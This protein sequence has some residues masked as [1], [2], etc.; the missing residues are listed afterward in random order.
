[1]A[2]PTRVIPPIPICAALPGPDGEPVVLD[3]ATSKVAL[4]KVRV[5]MN[6]GVQGGGRHAHR[7][8]RP[9]DQRS[10]GHVH[11]PA[12]RHPRLRRA[13]GLR[14][15]RHCRTAGRRADRRRHLP[16]GHRHHPGHPQQHAVIVVDPAK[17]GGAATWR[18]DMARFLAWIKASPP[19]PRQRRRAGG[20]RAGAPQPGRAAARR[21]P[22]RRH[23]LGR[24][25]RGGKLGRRAA[26]TLDA[27]AEAG[28][29]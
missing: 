15:R 7:R 8:G 22:H 4:G 16:R 6:K 28:Q 26:A 17:L 23:H 9:A 12:R 24:D 5:A 21:H 25:R 3:M 19:G 11:E 1:M 2:A 13:Q 27:A 10:R 20:R 18:D 29:P 14:P